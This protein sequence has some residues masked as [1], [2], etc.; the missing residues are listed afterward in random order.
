MTAAKIRLF[1]R[2]RLAGT[3]V[4]AGLA[5][6]VATL[7]WPHPTSFVVF[8]VAA[9]VLVVPGVALYLVAITSSSLAPPP[10]GPGPA[11]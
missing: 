9:T 10:A 5:V 1:R 6:E 4:C 11:P 8:L 3:L 7:F 2:L